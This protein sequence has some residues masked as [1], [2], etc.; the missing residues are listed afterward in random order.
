MTSTVTQ[1]RMGAD[2]PEWL[3]TLEP[4]TAQSKKENFRFMVDVDVIE[5]EQVFVVVPRV[6]GPYS[7]MIDTSGVVDCD[8]FAPGKPTRM[9]NQLMDV[10]ARGVVPPAPLVQPPPP[11]PGGPVRDPHRTFWQR[12]RYAFTGR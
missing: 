5:T 9:A 6:F 1:F 10:F 12:L 4:R 7:G 11:S 3:L 8:M 2:V